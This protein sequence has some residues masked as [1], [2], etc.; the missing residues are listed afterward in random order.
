MTKRLLFVA[1]MVFAVLPT[2]FSQQGRIQSVTGILVGKTKA[3]G[4]FRPEPGRLNIPVRDKKGLFWN[5]GKRKNPVIKW[6]PTA[7]YLQEDPL[8]KKQPA[9]TTRRR[10]TIT[11]LSPEIDI[12]LEGMTDADLTPADPTLCVGPNHLIQ[13]VNGPSGSYLQVFNKSGAPMM[14]RIYLDNL[15]EKS[16]YS[17]AGDGICLYDQFADRYIM[18][19]FGTPTGSTDINTLIFF[20]SKTND[21]LGEWYIYKFTDDSYFPDYPKI[22]VWDEKAYYATS[23]DFNLPENSFAGV[24]FYAF[25]RQQMLSGSS[26]VDLQRIR[27]TDAEKYDGAAPINV[28][29]NAPPA[30][31]PGL[32]AYRNDDGRTAAPDADS[33][34]LLAFDVDF[35]VPA[36]S[37]FTHTGSFPTAPFNTVICS[38]GG[39]FQACATVPNNFSKLMATTAFL[40]D[41]QSYRRFPDH[42]SLL[43]YHTVNAAAPGIAGIRWHEL[44]KTTGNWQLYQ[45]GTYAPDSLHRFYPSMNM[46]SKGQIAAVFNASSENLWP[47]IR[48]AGRNDSDPPGTF[49]ADETSVVTGSG[50]GTF[51]SRWG[52]YSMIAPDPVNDSIFWLTSMY[53][54]SNG[55]RTRIA[56]VKIAVTRALDAKLFSIMSPLS[57]QVFCSPAGIATVVQIGNSGSQTLRSAQLNWQLNNGPVQSTTWNGSLTHGNTTNVTL[58]VTYGTEGNYDLRVFLTQPNG[59]PDERTSN[60]TLAIKLRVQVPVAGP[61]SESFESNVFPP[62][63]WTVINPNE[64]SVTWTRTTVAANSGNAS[65]FINLFQ[66]NSVDDLDY[67][68][69]PSI[70]LQNADTVT[71]GFAHAYK[72]YSVTGDFADSLILMA[73]SDCGNTFDRVVWKQGGANLASTTGTTGDINWVPSADDWKQ[74][75]ISL[76]VSSLGN[77]AS[78][79]FAWVSVN[80]FGQNIYVDDINISTS[81]MPERD[82]QVIA[83]PSPLPTLCDNRFSPQVTVRNN[84][85]ETINSFVLTLQVD[86]QPVVTRTITGLQVLTGETHVVT[87]DSIYTL[88]NAGN[89]KLQVAIS[90]PNN[91]PDLLPANDSLL[92]QFFLFT[93][94]TAPLKESFESAGFPPANWFVVNYGNNITWTAT[95]IASTDGS[96]SAFIRNYANRTMSDSDNLYLPPVIM[97]GA[98]SIILKFDLAHLYSFAGGEQPDTL[99]LWV[100]TDCGVTRRL[101]YSKW[102]PELHTVNG[103]SR[104]GEFVPASRAEWRTDSLDLA[105]IVEPGQSFQLYFRNISNAGNNLYL[106]NIRI[107]TVTLP[108]KLKQ[109]GYLV[110]PNPTTGLVYVRHYRD[111]EKLRRIEVVNLQGQRI[112]S[113]SFSGNAGNMITIDLG[114][115]SSGVYVVRLIYNSS[116]RNTRII[117]TNR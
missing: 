25:N 8:R 26:N 44:R 113:Q 87:I 57:G 12:N 43:I 64:G 19:E 83:V 33:I 53:G 110:T 105:G 41:K 2:L 16:G 38:D 7:L 65:A 32:F 76:S 42:E 90:Q 55:W 21:P 60:D 80:K 22:S 79:T 71:I 39:Y 58:P 6:D 52:D 111:Q 98:D 46:N 15:V 94:T 50:Y 97:P 89:H 31:S 11:P 77:P 93:N 59:Q 92:Y 112:W 100:T 82:L 49:S 70:N 115:Q 75:N 69:S 101:L 62:A 10:A 108:A 117:K 29:G 85:R 63:G 27:M 36:N 88:A 4:K 67:L 109:D 99:Q 86:E 74:N 61:V 68:V 18:M 17:G 20:V 84:G 96:R 81:F 47:S 91:Q 48:V 102:G 23:R 103:P 45:E 72:P 95:D 35:A 14:D 51:S 104:E 37:R 78:I 66:Y 54:N 114:R 56:S 5:R 73:S 34:G 28:F 116:V 3:L 13:I 24:S 9:P 1:W 40:M 106:D 30:G 107:D